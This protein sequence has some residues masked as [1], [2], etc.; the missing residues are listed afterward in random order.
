MK[1]ILLVLCLCTVG[2]FFNFSGIANAMPYVFSFS[3]EDLWS[4]TP[5]DSTRLYN[6]DTPRRH[7]TSWKNDVQTTDSAQGNVSQYDSISGT[8]G[9]LQTDTYDSWLDAGGNGPKDN[10]GN[11]FG[12]A[13]FNLWGAGWSN[14]RFA[15]NERYRV[16]EGAGA[17]KIL[18]TPVGWTSEIVENPWP[19]NG[20]GSPLD[21]YFVQWTADDFA[22]RI[23]YDSFG[24]GTD[25][26]IFSY[27]V[28]IIGE[29][30]TTLELSPDG[31][32]FEE[33][34]SMRVWFGGLAMNPDGNLT[35][36]GY[37]GVM[38]LTPVEPVPEPTTVALLG[39]GLVGM[40][41]A[42]VRRRRKKK[43][44]DKS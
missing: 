40:A 15:F 13:Q 32:P 22:N 4:H 8:N 16:N 26:Y 11:D 30:A 41:G 25:D 9:W 19:D 7:H 37:D 39:I 14:G 18:D 20:S 12:I 3:E 36:E 35:N 2:L 24:N 28:D 1:K 5:S 43:T 10:A 29:Y 17:W 33:D 23:L 42:E 31:N 38:S 34:G 44:V 27:E 6:Q 21:Q